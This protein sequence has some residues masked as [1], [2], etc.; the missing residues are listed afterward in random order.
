M[1]AGEKEGRSM[2]VEPGAGPERFTHV[3]Q[4]AKTLQNMQVISLYTITKCDY[5][6]W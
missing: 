1:T 6:I 4:R 2:V 3:W 5:L